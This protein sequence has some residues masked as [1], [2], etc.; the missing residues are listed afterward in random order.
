MPCILYKGLGE[1]QVWELRRKEMTYYTEQNCNSCPHAIPTLT[2]VHPYQ[3]SFTCWADRQ[4]RA[5]LC[6]LFKVT[7]PGN[8][9]N[10]NRMN[11]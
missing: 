4:A 3:G 7:V 2:K 9:K 11:V 5:W 8:R 1:R 10:G 6:R